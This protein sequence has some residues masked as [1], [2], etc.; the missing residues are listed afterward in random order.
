MSE[1]LDDVT[2]GGLSVGKG[3]NT[4]EACARGHGCMKGRGRGRKLWMGRR[5]GRGRRKSRRGSRYGRLLEDASD[6]MES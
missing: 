6:S 3:K 1:N 4:V 5:R 2:E